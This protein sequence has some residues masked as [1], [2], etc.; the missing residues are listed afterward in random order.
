MAG[1]A[2][3][4]IIMGIYKRIVGWY[5]INNQRSLWEN[6]LNTDEN[7]VQN[8]GHDRGGFTV[9]YIALSHL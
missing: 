5:Y 7:H 9:E 3:P 1:F 4:L 6:G 8:D 2:V